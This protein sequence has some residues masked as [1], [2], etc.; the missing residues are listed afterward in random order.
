MPTMNIEEAQAHLAQIIESLNPGEP[1][2]ITKDGEPVA[3]LTRPP[4]T[5]WPCKAGS[6]KEIPHWMAPDFDAPIEDF[7]DY[8]E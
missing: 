1:L 8:M 4:A 2:I 6:A 5:R 7:R 3:T